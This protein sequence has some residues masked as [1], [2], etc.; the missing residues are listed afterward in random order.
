MAQPVDAVAHDEPH[1]ASVEIRPHGFR[2]IFPLGGQHRLCRLGHRIV[3]G[4]A[5]E[6]ARALR[7]LALQRMEQPLGM[8]NALGIAPDFFADDAESIAVL[9][10]AAHPA[11]GAVIE[12]LHL[13][14]AGRGAIMGAHRNAGLDVKADVHGCRLT[15]MRKQWYHPLPRAIF[16][17]RTRDDQVSG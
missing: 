9:L 11:N 6:F 14:R 7:P 3:P 10:G 2:P 15:E 4:N 17:S 8:V 12:Q 13:Q 5:G 1:G 16:R